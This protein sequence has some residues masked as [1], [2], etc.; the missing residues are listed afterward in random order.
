MKESEIEELRA[1][2]ELRKSSPH[3]NSPNHAMESLKKELRTVVERSKAGE[4]PGCPNGKC[5]VALVFPRCVE[6]SCSMCLRM[7][8]ADVGNTQ[9]CFPAGEARCQELEQMISSLEEERNKHIS[10]IMT[11]EEKMSDLEVQCASLDARLNQRSAQLSDLQREITEKASE[12]VALEREVSS[13]AAA[14]ASGGNQ[15]GGGVPT[16]WPGEIF[17]LF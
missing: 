9:H 3:K 7:K 17:L 1:E 5:V 10:H 12:V 14:A 6:F 2:L 11:L 16:P 15:P 4:S 8:E 13:A